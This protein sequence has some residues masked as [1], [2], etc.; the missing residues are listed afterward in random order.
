MDD[1]NTKAIK[2]PGAVYFIF[3]ASGDLAHRKLYPALYSM[4]HSGKLAKDFAIIGLATEQQSHDKFCDSLYQSI[5]EFGH[6]KPQ[7]NNQEWKEFNEHVQY[8][9]LDIKDIEGFHRVKEAAKQMEEKF[10]ITGNR[11]F[12]LALPPDLFGDVTSN[13]K[14]GGLLESNGWHRLVIEKP[15]GSDLASA[16]KLNEDIHKVFADREV[17]RL[18]HYLGKEMV[19]NISAFRF[20]N[21]FFESVWNNKYIANIQI[22]M[23]ETVGVEE[24]GGYYDHAGAL[25]DMGQNHMLQML[26]V[27]AM[28]PPGRLDSEDVHDEKEKVF[29][30]LRPYSTAAQVH[31]HVVRGQYSAGELDGKSKLAYQ[32][33]KS[34]ADTSDTE[35]YFAA[36]VFVDNFRWAGVP[37]YI[38]TGKRLPV[39]TTEIVIEFKNV[40]DHVY[41]TKKNKLEPNL[42]VFRISPIEGLYFRVNAKNPDSNASAASIIPVAMDINQESLIGPNTTEGYELLLYDAAC[43]DTSCFTRW[44]EVALAWAFVDKITEVWAEDKQKPKLYPAG[45]WGPEEVQQL[46]EK[47][48]FHWWPVT[49][50]LQNEEVGQ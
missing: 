5:Q 15:F 14:K 24:R 49:G 19:Q 28:E 30:A 18:D 6:C 23:S 41:Y 22:T 44:E 33:E 46:L 42:L 9:S 29:R 7:S 12:Y 4:Y 38:R 45:S 10:Q 26:A 47:D 37:F 40:P 13:I 39:K 36:R 48:G 27:M 16:Q 34:V 8:I 1:K 43:G 20:G 25:R 11:L 17:Y 3:G 21:A 50:Q 2:A 31:K 32:A 35:T